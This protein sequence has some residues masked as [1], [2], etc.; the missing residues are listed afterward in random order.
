MSAELRLDVFP[1]SLQ[2]AYDWDPSNQCQTSLVSASPLL[3]PS[4][5]PTPSF[6]LDDTLNQNGPALGF[7]LMALCILLLFYHRPAPILRAATDS[8]L[9]VCAPEA[10]PWLPHSDTWP[11]LGLQLWWI[12]SPGIAGWPIS[13]LTKT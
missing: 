10:P 12:P 5:L 2:F 1:L 3:D 6:C 9:R 11:C 8:Y 13:P 4:Q 7:C